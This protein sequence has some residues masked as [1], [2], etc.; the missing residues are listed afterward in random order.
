[1]KD[2]LLRAGV[3]LS[4]EPQ[5]WKFLVVV[6]ETTSKKVHQKA[7]RKCSRNI[8]LKAKKLK[9]TLLL[10]LLLT[11]SVTLLFFQGH[12]WRHKHASHFEKEEV[13]KKYTTN[14]FCCN[15]DG[16][17]QL[18]DTES[19]LKEHVTSHVGT[20]DKACMCDECGATFAAQQNLFKH[21]KRRH[22]GPMPQPHKTHRCEK[23]DK[24]FFTSYQL[25]VHFR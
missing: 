18:F 24:S 20:T 1:M 5:I 12:L 14:K 4:S 23:C 7:C 8:F 9:L 6:W 2:L 10:L 22:S 15:F 11:L 17:D 3:Q 21:K 25:V 19:E 13:Q 16:C